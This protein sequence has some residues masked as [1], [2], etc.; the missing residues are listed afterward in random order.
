MLLQNWPASLPELMVGREVVNCI[1]RLIYLRSLISPNG[2]VPG[3]ISLKLQE[4]ML[5]IANL[6]RRRDI[7]LPT[8]GQVYCTSVCSILLM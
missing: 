2:L 8:K 6:W 3:K 5:A 1:D 7:R 4:A